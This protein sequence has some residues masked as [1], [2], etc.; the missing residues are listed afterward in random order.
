MNDKSTFYSPYGD[1]FW[2]NV[3]LST[4]DKLSKIVDE[5]SKKGIFA[6]IFLTV[7]MIIAFVWGVTALIDGKLSDD[8][9]MVLFLLTPPI[10]VP[11]IV[12]AM[13]RSRRYQLKSREGR[14]R[15]AHI[16]IMNRKMDK[17]LVKNKFVIEI[18]S[19]TS[20]ATATVEVE[21]GFYDKAGVGITGWFTM[22]EDEGTGLLASPYWFTADTDPKAAGLIVPRREVIADEAS[23]DS[24]NR[25]YDAPMPQGQ[26][27]GAP[28]A[29][30]VSDA[31]SRATVSTAS[32]DDLA[33]AYFRAHLLNVVL[34]SISAGLF[35]IGGL[36]LLLGSAAGFEESI[37][38][39]V[40]IAPYLMILMACMA[41]QI[42]VH[43]HESSEGRK[44]ATL[45]LALQ[46]VPNMLAAFPLAYFGTGIRVILSFFLLL[47]NLFMIFLLNKG[48]I[49]TCL[50]IKK[51]NCRAMDAV[52]I[53]KNQNTRYIYPF[54]L[55]KMCSCVVK[56]GTDTYEIKITASQYKTYFEGMS[57]TM[58]TLDKNG[59]NVFVR[60]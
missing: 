32:S 45:Y 24:E 29:S 35:L 49:D 6:G 23:A 8:L 10:L 4:R 58:V 42:P 54:F 18:V 2:D 56:V 27:F 21:K 37:Y 60:A 7:M 1:D 59:N 30:V 39:R 50:A 3:D 19:T 33:T 25:S 26:F 44:I 38:G 11:V 46:F 31:S 48:L 51:G 12:S 40:V 22:V 17:S 47:F 57:G 28:S 14:I 34:S 16:R 15:V 52:L 43:M 41:A 55:I 9:R 36:W 13:I 5:D 53:S 20:D